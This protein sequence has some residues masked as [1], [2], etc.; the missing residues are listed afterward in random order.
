MDKQ[1]NRAKHKK[2]RA[3]LLPDG[4]LV[5]VVC[6]CIF[7]ATRNGELDGGILVTR[8]RR[9]HLGGNVDGRSAGV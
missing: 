9:E 1:A 3:S 7:E 5:A 4:E 6:K 2:L 8:G